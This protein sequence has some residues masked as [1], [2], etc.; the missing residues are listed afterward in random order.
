MC[1]IIG[2][3]D[4]SGNPVF[5]R[6]YRGMHSIQHR[7]Q[8]AAGL[9]TF[10][11]RFHLAKGPGLIRDVFGAKEAKLLKGSIGIGHVRYPTV[12]GG[13]WEDAQPFWTSTPFGIGIAHNGNLSNFQFIKSHF[14]KVHQSLI[15]SDC[16]V[17]ALLC[18]LGDELMK[19]NGSEL[20]PEKIF[21]AVDGV[22]KRARGAFSVVAIIADYGLLAFR[23]PYGIRPL[24]LGSR[25]ESN[26][27]HSFCFASESVVLDLLDYHGTSNVGAGEAVLID[28][29][30][31]VH[32]KVVRCEKHSPCIFEWIY[33]AR[34]DSFIDGISV[35]KT[36]Q[37]LGEKLAMKWK[38]TGVQADVII[39]VPE[40]AN[41]AAM[42][43]AG[44][45]QIPYR[46]G[47]VKNR[48]IGRTFIMPRDVSRGESVRLKLNTIQIEFKDK[49]VLL[50]DDSI[51][52]GNTS[53]SIISIARKAGAKKVYMASYSPPLL[54][55]CVYGIDMCTKKDFVAK[56][57]NTDTIAQAIGADF[58]L[59]QDLFDMLEAAKEGN[60]DI[61]SYCSA[62]FTG[63]YPTGDVTQSTL[64]L[65]EA[66]RERHS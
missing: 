57:S 27:T 44:V 16:D 36:R 19:H 37:R 25:S 26:G 23:D 1:G 5:E 59:Y 24:I 17:E 10:S 28:K 2:I 60:S 9:L 48:Y 21:A 3:L 14:R 55:P 64:D 43:M 34:P 4:A 45:L 58:V 32:R 29:H 22:L 18:L 51:V 53:R 30:G 6:L 63:S 40:S 62:C 13:S 15:N 66:D 42:S 11:N 35:Y 20:T 54:H 33:F 50:V 56:D 41:T 7:G 38:K 31:G 61:E 8:D 39:P 47:L 52:R 65:I 46:E 49:N 12:G